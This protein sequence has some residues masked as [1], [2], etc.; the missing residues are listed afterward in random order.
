MSE[1]AAAR[2]AADLIASCE[3]WDATLPWLEEYWDFH[4]LRRFHSAGF[5]F[6]SATIQDLPPTFGGVSDGIRR[7]LAL[8]KAHESWLTFASTTREVVLAHRDGKL[9]VGFNVQNTAQLGGDLSR[10]QMLRELGVRHM[11]LAYQTRN[12]VAAGCADTADAGL[13]PFGRD[14]V[15]EMNRVGIVVDCSHTGHRSSLEAMEISN[16]PTIFSHSNAYAVCPHIRNLRDDQIRLCA[17]MGGVIG[18]VGIGSFLGDAQAS[19]GSVFRHLDYIVS[20]VGPDHVGLGTDFVRDMAG[21]WKDIDAQKQ[22]EWPDP[23]GTQ[24]YEG[25]CFQ[26]EQLLE[27]VTMM[28]T[29]GYPR[30]AIQAILG[31]NFA[32]VYGASE[33]A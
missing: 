29:H 30:E 2:E 6:V 27:L 5:D 25:G 12:D 21:V 23:T 19:T 17:A 13:T 26:P 16:R 14:V 9:A 11:L 28:M 15:R 1:S 3:V 8:A 4:T 32:R 18:I 31:G 24:L 33:G 22:T 20:L 10:I 7:F